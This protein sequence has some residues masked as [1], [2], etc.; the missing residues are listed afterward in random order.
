MEQNIENKNTK[1]PVKKN[2]T[3]AIRFDKTFMR[4]VT[5]LVDKAN[6]KQ[7]GRKVKAKA[8]LTNLLELADEKLIEEVIL[9]TQDESLSVNDKKEMYMKENLSKFKGTKDEF[10]QK[11]MELMSGFLSQNPT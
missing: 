7:Y 1:T 4:Q 6:K 10:E 5:K 3:T 8:L 9:K 11:M 2:D